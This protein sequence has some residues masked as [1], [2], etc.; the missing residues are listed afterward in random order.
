MK[1]LKII[2]ATDVANICGSDTARDWLLTYSANLKES[3]VVKVAFS[4]EIDE[5]H[6]RVLPYIDFSR[7]LA[8]CE[9]CQLAN[10]V[11]PEWK[12]MYCLSCGND[13]SGKAIPVEFPPNWQEIEEAL[14]CRPQ[15]NPNKIFKNILDNAIHSKPLMEL[16]HAWHGEPLADLIAANKEKGLVKDG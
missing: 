15:I 4:G 2:T 12:Y 10:Y 16:R 5:T 3:R 11:G 6:P 7:W 1:I 13:G 8:K 9:C 14:L